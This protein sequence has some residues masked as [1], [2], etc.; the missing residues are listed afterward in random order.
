VGPAGLIGRRRTR[1]P[2]THSTCLP[3]HLEGMENRKKEAGILCLPSILLGGVGDGR[4]AERRITTF[5]TVVK[6]RPSL[7]CRA[8]AG[9]VCQSNMQGCISMSSKAMSAPSSPPSR[10]LWRRISIRLKLR[11]RHMPTNDDIKHARALFRRIRAERLKNT[12]QARHRASGGYLRVIKDRLA[13]KL[14]LIEDEELRVKVR[15]AIL[16]ADR[17]LTRLPKVAQEA[18]IDALCEAA[19]YAE[20][21][22]RLKGGRSRAAAWTQDLLV[23]DVCDALCS[24]GIPVP[25]K[26]KRDHSVAQRLAGN[27]AVLLG[28][29][30]SGR[31][32]HTDATGQRYR[33]RL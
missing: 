17:S 26:L 30:G 11:Q 27:I 7:P 12:L 1:L 15:D 10:M 4:Q 14:V 9:R 32:T 18:L 5:T 23:R 31:A 29:A 6:E 3:L 13:T 33:T 16:N 2:S 21:G 22:M 8:W 20:A 28:L 24:A 25:L 19:R